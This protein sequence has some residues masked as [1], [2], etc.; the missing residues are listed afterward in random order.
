MK[1]DSLKQELL[2]LGIDVFVF[3]RA[4]HRHILKL[5]EITISRKTDTIY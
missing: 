2:E 4:I 5:L 1:Q 3:A